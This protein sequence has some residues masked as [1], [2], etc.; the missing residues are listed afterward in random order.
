MSSTG[1]RSA[2][3]R[4][5]GDASARPTARSQEPTQSKP[6]RS[7]AQWF[8]LLAGLGLLLGG[9]LGMTAD[10]NFDTTSTDP[11][12]VLQGDGFLGF[13]V[14]GWHNLV[15]ILSGLFLL[16]GFFR[17]GLAKT[18]AIIFGV[19]YLVLLIIGLI[20]GNDILD[21]VPVNPADNGLHG[22]LALLALGAGLLS[23]KRTVEDTRGSEP[24]EVRTATPSSRERIDDVRPD[25]GRTRDGGGTVVA[26]ADGDGVDRPDTLRPR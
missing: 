15:H 17:H 11:N 2:G 24:R 13:E 5:N 19:F 25:T 3:G 21:F 10:N 14:N 9:I 6:G 23:T 18:V 7:L 8:C 12:G 4:S 16:F 26:P 20:D 1:A 22:V